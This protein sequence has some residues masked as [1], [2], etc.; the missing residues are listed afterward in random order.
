M[1]TNRTTHDKRTSRCRWDYDNMHSCI[2]RRQSQPKRTKLP[3]HS[4]VTRTHDYILK[5]RF[6]LQLL[7]QFLQPMP[8]QLKTRPLY[9][10]VHISIIVRHIVIYKSAFVFPTRVFLW[11]ARL[12]NINI[13]KY[14]YSEKHSSMNIIHKL[15]TFWKLKVHVLPKI[16][17]E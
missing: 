2:V 9:S 4:T 16:S 5:P 14:K 17:L 1:E 15:R 12:T 6:F 3:T 8:F 11:T 13:T 7:S 10:V